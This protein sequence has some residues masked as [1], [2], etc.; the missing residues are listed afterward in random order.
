MI[1]F[2]TILVELMRGV[3][4]T[5]GAIT[6]LL[7]YYG[8]LTTFVALILI[9]VLISRLIGKHLSS[10]SSDKARKKGDKQK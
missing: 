6:G 3:M 8:A 5:V 10:G 2:H 4:S 7:T 1:T 9:H